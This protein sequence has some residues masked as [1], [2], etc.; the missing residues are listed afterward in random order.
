MEQLQAEVQEQNENVLDVPLQHLRET[1]FD[2]FYETLGSQERGLSQR[3]ESFEQIKKNTQVLLAFTK[4]L[5]DVTVR[6]GKVTRQ[7]NDLNLAQSKYMS[8]LDVQVE[9]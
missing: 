1:T 6:L 7:G 8:A 2:F 5:I 3:K 4:D 9:A